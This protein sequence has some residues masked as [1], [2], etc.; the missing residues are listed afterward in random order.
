MEHDT[1]LRH[2]LPSLF[3]APIATALLS[4]F[5]DVAAMLILTVPGLAVETLRCGRY[6]ARVVT[7]VGLAAATDF[8]GASIL[9]SFALEV[10][11]LSGILWEYDR[12]RRVCDLTTVNFPP[13]GGSD[14]HSG[15]VEACQ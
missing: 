10:T 3:V 9:N 5:T 13:R 6:Q 8:Q 14:T 7:E 2:A 12:G 4:R 11:V 15:Y 1:C